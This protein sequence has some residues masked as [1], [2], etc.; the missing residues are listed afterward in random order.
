MGRLEQELALLLT[1]RDVSMSRTL[2]GA[3]REL[4]RFGAIA[5][6]A[7]RNA[8][9]NLERGVVVGATAAAGAIGYSIKAAMDFESTS[10]SVA[11]TVGDAWQGVVAANRE[12]ATTIPVDVNTLNEIS[13]AAGA[14]GVEG[15]SD[16]SAF[17][18]TVA[19]LSQTADDV[20][21]GAASEFLGHLR[22]NLKLT[23][24]EIARVGDLTTQLGNSTSATE[25]DILS[26]AESV[27]GAASFI[28]ASTDDVFAWSA[29]M[30]SAGEEA[31]AGGSAIQRV[32][33]SSAK[34]VAKGGDELK[35]L[36]KI[37]GVSMAQFKKNFA[38]DGAGTLASFMTKLGALTDAEQ[39]AILE[40][41]GWDD[42]RITRALGKL[43]GNVENLEG[44]YNQT[45][46]AA[47]AMSREAE[48]RFATTASQVEILKNNVNDAAITIGSELLP[49]VNELAGEATTWL[50][51]HPEEIAKFARELADAMR[52]AVDYAKG[53]DWDAIAGSLKAGAGAAKLIVDSFLSLPAPI[54]Q[55]L[56]GGYIANK[57]T[58][59]A[60]TDLAGLGLRMA[61]RQMNVT[62]GTVIV[63]GGVAGAG[64]AAAGAAGGAGGK[65][66]LLGRVFGVLA[67]AEI[68]AE[69]HDEIAGLGAEIGRGIP[70]ALKERMAAGD[71]LQ[72]QEWPFGPH[73][74]PD[75]ATS[76]PT[77]WAGGNRG[78]FER[79][80][81]SHAPVPGGRADR[82]LTG[83]VFTAERIKAEID[84]SG[85]PGPR[86]AKSTDRPLTGSVFRSEQTRAGQ[87]WKAI[88]AAQ[89]A[90]T[91][92]VDRAAAGVDRTAA[93][94]ERSKAAIDWNR[95]AVQSSASAI[96]AAIRAARTQ[97]SLTIPVSVS[98][99]TQVIRRYYETGGGGDGS[100]NSYDL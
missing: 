65:L 70:F 73:D 11:K 33:I 84:W 92:K 94:V 18:K 12:L 68:A 63:N 15:V 36:A 61:L 25:G 72:A 6:K 82:P 50:K 42:I 89:K 4:D 53:L 67:V 10:A 1:G 38:K 30:A 93:A 98:N 49:I 35:T 17:T 28:N 8:G 40:S 2:R 74:A 21:S 75:W 78:V 45:G 32:W 96:V 9:R 76:T 51:E 79:T 44:A 3:N 95:Q 83:S 29:A 58:G 22:T 7:G 16:I 60:V 59:G 66:G 37:S 39:L 77:A 80:P 13:A 91:A 43:L 86:A 88:S 55:L 100:V 69:F 52:D 81:V 34:Y 62:A 99:Q 41:L 27:S 54:Q 56:A 97:I 71:W 47:G 26:M 85:Y 24:P 46:K 31:E 48:I 87:D 64:G 90:T 57:I 5:G 20:D 19:L 14:M 23:G